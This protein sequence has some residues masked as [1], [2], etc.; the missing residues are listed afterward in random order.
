MYNAR[1]WVLLLATT[2]LVTGNSVA[3]VAGNGGLANAYVR[4]VHAG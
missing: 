1:R 4:V 2:F 3:Y